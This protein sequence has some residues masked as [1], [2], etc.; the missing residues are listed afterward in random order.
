MASVVLKHTDCSV[1]AH[2]LVDSCLLIKHAAAK[3][4]LHSGGGRLGGWWLA[5]SPLAP[6]HSHKLGHAWLSL[7]ACANTILDFSCNQSSATAVLKGFSVGALLQVGKDLEEAYWRPGNGAAFLDLVHQ[8]TG[9]ALSADAWVSML[10]QPVSS[11]V[12]Q[13]E[14]EYKEAVQKGPKIKPGQH[15]CPADGH[16]IMSLSM[17]C[18]D[19]TDLGLKHTTCTGA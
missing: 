14:Q 2:L 10:K 1:Y 5:L 19:E 15:A 9:E 4:V 17:F 13:E 16:C 18:T 7:S 3:R 12:H 11:V 6:L 8:L